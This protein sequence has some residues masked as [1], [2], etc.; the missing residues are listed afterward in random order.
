MRLTIAALAITLSLSVTAFAHGN[1]QHV[2]GKVTQI[3]SN[4]I[5]VETTEKKSVTFEVSDQT[6]FQKSGSAATLK[7]LKIGD[8]VVIHAAKQG[9]KLVAHEV[10]F[11]ATKKP[12][13]ITH[14]NRSQPSTPGYLTNLI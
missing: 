3:S 13:P 4:S 14:T 6:S 5:T 11:G 8:K 2:M 1:E 12:H 10:R 9:E 7:D